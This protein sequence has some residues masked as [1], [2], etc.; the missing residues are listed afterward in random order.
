MVWNFPL[1]V[2]YKSTN[3]FGWPQLIVAVYGLDAFGRDVIK[4][5][6]C[7]H[8]PTSPGR[9]VKAIILP[10]ARCM[11]IY[12]CLSAW[13]RL[14]YL[15]KMH[16]GIAIASSG[17]R[18][19]RQIRYW[20]LGR[21]AASSFALPVCRFDLKLRLF[22]PCS[23]SLIQSFT[24]WLSGMPAEFSDPR[25]PSYGEGREVTRVESSGVVNVSVNIMTK[26]MEQFGYD[27]GAGKDRSRQNVT[28]L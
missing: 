26:D 6:G 1:D 5:Y 18:V 16:V 10:T 19:L 7:M 23:A 28:V 4:G 15:R 11:Y 24:S 3:A 12:C 8:L 20:W 2:T 27:N 13:M 22:K 25:F 17:M 14:G 9:Y 21:V